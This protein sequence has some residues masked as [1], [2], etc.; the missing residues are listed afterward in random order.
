[1]GSRSYVAYIDPL[2]NG[3]AAYCH[4]GAPPEQNGHTLLQNYSDPEDA[5][6]RALANLGRITLWPNP[7][8]TLLH[9]TPRP[10]H[11]F[12]RGTQTFFGSHW[13]L[14]IEWLYAWTPD[15][16][17][18]AP[19]YRASPALADLHFQDKDPGDP[20]W[21]PHL[22]LLRKHQSPV[23]LGWLIQQ[24]AASA[25]PDLGKIRP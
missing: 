4:I 2:V 9:S 24:T 16:W 14:G 23:P 15:G 1:M 8:D 17:F 18:V 20:E 25:G 6:A 11:T 10:P 22:K 21:L 12:T 19:G 5:H 13:G 3:T 7:K